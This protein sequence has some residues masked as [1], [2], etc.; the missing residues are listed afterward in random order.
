MRHPLGRGTPPLFCYTLWGGRPPGFATPP[1]VPD[2][3]CRCA[4][5]PGSLGLALKP[6]IR[7]KMQTSRVSSIP[8]PP[9][10]PRKFS[11]HSPFPKPG[12]NN[13]PVFLSNTIRMGPPCAP[14]GRNPRRIFTSYDQPQGVSDWPRTQFCDDGVSAS[15]K[16]PRD[17][18]G[19]VAICEGGTT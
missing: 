11:A 3:D 19:G 16:W 10:K 13:S 17:T 5:V 6:E 9:L 8:R 18:D 7:G 15:V 1:W 2:P 12:G 14:T 4:V